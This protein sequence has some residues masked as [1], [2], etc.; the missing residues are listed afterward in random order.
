V[1]ATL[2]DLG[3]RIARI[4]APGTLDGGDVLRVGDTAYV[5]VSAVLCKQGRSPI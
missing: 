2:R 4:E 5:G 1:E 3:Y